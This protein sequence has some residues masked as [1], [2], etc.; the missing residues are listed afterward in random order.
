MYKLL[1][2]I[3]VGLGIL[4]S[5]ACYGQEF[6]NVPLGAL[7]M[8]Y[9]SSFA[10]QA[11]SARFSS[12]FR[13]GVTQEPNY[14]SRGYQLFAS[15]DQFIPA[16]RSGIGIT[17]GYHNGYSRSESTT[18]YFFNY[19]TSIKYAGLAVAPKFSFKGKYTLSPSLDFNFSS[20]NFQYIANPPFDTIYN[21]LNGNHLAFNSRAGILFNTNKL[22][23]GYSMVLLSSS[24]GKNRIPQN[25]L[26]SYRFQSYFQ[27]GYTF[28]K[29]ETSKFSFTPQIV[30][31][32]SEHEFENRLN[33]LLA[34][35]NLNFRYKQFIWGLND[36][37]IHLGWQ[38]DKVR[39][40]LTNDYGRVSG[41]SNSLEGFRY[42]GNLSLRYIL[43][44][45]SKP[46]RSW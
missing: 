17:A 42:E 2:G 3:H 11:G 37:G 1:I 33:I 28:Q 7:P 23:I 9:N 18:G 26:Q 27:I 46:G 25:R 35:L 39:L 31:E 44:N 13:Y 10:G 14:L 30:I 15:Y 24:L 16:I 4:L 6:A 45:S 32:F 29:S 40:M 8:Q 38:T 12:N 34:G 22:Y 21:Y 20:S 43:G 5:S 19:S 36:E 41:L